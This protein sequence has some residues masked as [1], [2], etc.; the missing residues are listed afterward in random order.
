VRLG[1]AVT[2]CDAEGVDLGAERIA[3]GNIIWAA[4]VQAS[5]AGAWLGAETDRAGRILVEPDLSLPG[6]P[7]VFIVGDLAM[8]RGEGG[9]AVPGVA[10]AAKQAGVH[11]ARTIAARLAGKPAPG[12][13]RYADYGNLATVGRKAAVVDLTVPVFGALRFS[14]FFAWLFWLFAHIYF[15]IGFRNRFVVLLDWASAYWSAARYARVVTDITPEQHE[16]RA[17]R[18]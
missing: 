7:E 17:P 4:G 14:G 15:L 12:P 1:Q 5:P 6:H 13:F 16:E 8:I 3:A 2:G 10:P 18:A 11:A 9:K